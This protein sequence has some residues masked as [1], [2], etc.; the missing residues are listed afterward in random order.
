MDV[1]AVDNPAILA[2]WRVNEVGAGEE[3]LLCLYNLS[4]QQ[5]S[6]ALD[7]ADKR[8]QSLI[9]LLSGDQRFLITEWPVVINL[10]A[11][12]SHWLRLE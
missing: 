11:Y 2:Y 6:I 12:A 9:D 7:L 10:K 5:Q 1:L 4:N 8:G 3:R